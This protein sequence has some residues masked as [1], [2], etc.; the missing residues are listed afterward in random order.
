MSC[1]SEEPLGALSPLFD[2]PSFSFPATCIQ[3]TDI[4]TEV[5][6]KRAPG[7]AKALRLT[8]PTGTW[9]NSLLKDLLT[10]EGHAVLERS[11]MR[12]ARCLSADGVSDKH[13]EQISLDIPASH[14]YEGNTDLLQE[15]F[16]HESR[17]RKSLT[18]LRSSPKRSG[19]LSAHI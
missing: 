15:Y 1:R 17:F 8:Y 12:H 16:R 13:P 4:Y 6:V 10:L 11:E 18:N 2:T 3:I 9:I 19:D 7:A 14:D 5:L